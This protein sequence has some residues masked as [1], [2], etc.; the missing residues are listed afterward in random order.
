MTSATGS[1]GA[2]CGVRQT[3]A[4]IA[5]AAADAKTHVRTRS[6]MGMTQAKVAVPAAEPQRPPPVRARASGGRAGALTPLLKE[7]MVIR[8]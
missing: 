7:H 4:T 8:K 6:R 1:R 2:G 5:P 3:A